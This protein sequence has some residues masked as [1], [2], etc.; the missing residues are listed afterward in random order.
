MQID[1]GNTTLEPLDRNEI[2]GTMVG[3]IRACP[4]QCLNGRARDLLPQLTLRKAGSANR[5]AWG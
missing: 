2:S 5:Y 3:G 1:P 4:A